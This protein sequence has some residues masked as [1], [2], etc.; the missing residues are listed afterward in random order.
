M[1]TLLPELKEH[2]GITG[3]E[4]DAEILGNVREAQADIELLTG[5]RLDSGPVRFR[6]DHGDLPFLATLDMR[7]ATLQANAE[8]WPIP[9]PV[10]PGFANVLQL[11]RAQTAP[12]K[13]VP[14]AEALSAAAAGVAE[15]QR[16]GWLRQ[17]PIFWFLG[18]AKTMPAVELGQMLMD[19]GRLVHVPVAWST[20]EGWWFQ[21]S[22]RIL[23]V[24]RDP[25]E[26][27]GLVEILAPVGEL[28]LIATEPILIVARITSHP[29][30]WAFVARVWVHHGIR[31]HPRVWKATSQAVHG[32]GVPIVCLDDHSTPEEVVAEM[33][34]AAYWHGCLEG[35]DA[36]I[37]PALASAFP[38]DVARVR[39]GTGQ[40][41]NEA[42]AA[43]LF[44]R[45]LRPGFDPTRGAGSKPDPDGP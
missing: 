41:N 24:P 31:H 2:L 6:V 17:Q 13:A 26:E 12:S 10:D 14:I 30:D 16:Q 15:L 36:A 40:P 33:L 39:A 1:A 25:P 22:R 20:V 7:T 18:R 44:E 21:V 9:D 4:R 19:P 3:D 43:L 8:A 27:P 35:D 34:L 38:S 28:T 23:L 29:A 37:P 5:H 11:A 45:L 32:H 42:A